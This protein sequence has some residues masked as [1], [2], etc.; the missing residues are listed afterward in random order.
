M[1]AAAQWTLFLSPEFDL[2][3][4]IR[5]KW[6]ANMAMINLCLGAVLSTPPLLYNH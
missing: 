4:E 5:D 3:F 6:Q 1:I 2:F